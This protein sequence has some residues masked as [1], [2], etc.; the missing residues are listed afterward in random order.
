MSGH[1]NPGD[2]TGYG[3]VGKLCYINEKLVYGCICG[4][5]PAE[6]AEMSQGYVIHRPENMSFC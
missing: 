1:G 5:L 6:K 4:E 2:R 3:K